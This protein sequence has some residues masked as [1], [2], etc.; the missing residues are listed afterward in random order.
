MIIS[1]IPGNG[2]VDPM[3]HDL[4]PVFRRLPLWL[5]IRP[6]AAVVPSALVILTLFENE[7]IELD[8]ICILF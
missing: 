4:L 2:R 6:D 3:D 5:G 7:V 1:G 8:D